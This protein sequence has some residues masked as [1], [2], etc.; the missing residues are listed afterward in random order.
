MGLQRGK[1]DRIDAL[2]IAR[3][4]LDFQRHAQLWQP[5]SVNLER[6]ALLLSHRDRV[7]KNLMSLRST[8]NEQSGFVDPADHALTVALNA[9]A[10]A[11]LEQSRDRINA[12]IE[13][14]LQADAGL[15]RQQEN[16]Q[17]I[18]GFGP[19]IAAKLIEVTRGFSRLTEPRKLACFCG[20]AP[21]EH[22]SGTSIRGRTRVSPLANKDLKK[23]L[24]LAT[25]VTIRKGGI[26][27]EFYQRKVTE[28]K[29]KMSVINAIRNKLIHLLLACIKNDT[30]YQKN[31]KINVA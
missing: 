2:R 31:Y 15:R 9:P 24:H 19:V 30:M 17:S 28:G 14:I 11:G 1:N 23:M 3:Y 7:V 25:L 5:A 8:L 22:T 26:M 12:E 16:L 13:A 18:P 21:F 4:A 6:L 29:H 20:V 10:I 27:Y